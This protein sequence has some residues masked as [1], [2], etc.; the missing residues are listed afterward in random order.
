M[1]FDSRR[2]ELTVYAAV[3]KH[4]SARDDRDEALWALLI[5]ELAMV[6]EDPKYAPIR[7]G[8]EPNREG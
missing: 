3:S 6:V 4:N 5:A 1:G 8:F 2:H 7:A